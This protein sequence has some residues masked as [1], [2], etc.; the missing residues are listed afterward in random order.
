MGHFYWLVIKA[1]LAYDKGEYNQAERDRENRRSQ[2]RCYVIAQEERW[3]TRT[4]P[5]GHSLMAI[6][7]LTE[8][9]LI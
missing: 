9:G 3:N 4:L 8:I 7:R 1:T 2:D 5:V 6:H